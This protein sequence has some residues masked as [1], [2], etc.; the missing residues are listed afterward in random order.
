[1]PKTNGAWIGAFMASVLVA[2][3]LSALLV[4]AEVLVIK[5]WFPK[6]GVIAAL[7]YAVRIISLAGASI[8]FARS[9]ALKAWQRG[10]LLGTVYWGILCF[11]H[12]QYAQQQ[13]QWLSVLIDGV[14]CIVISFASNVAFARR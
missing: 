9:D 8:V 6:D 10:L 11:L 4:I 1:M 14:I 5:T 2:V 13:A 3:I 12:M 7:N